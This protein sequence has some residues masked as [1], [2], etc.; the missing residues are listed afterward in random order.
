[1]VAVGKVLV[2]PQKRGIMPN[3]IEDYVQLTHF[4]TLQ[5]CDPI[6]ANSTYDPQSMF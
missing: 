4:T 5:L 1:M 2:I 6:D 3:N